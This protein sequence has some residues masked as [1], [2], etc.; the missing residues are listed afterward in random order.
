MSAYTKAGGR[1]TSADH[2]NDPAARICLSQ[3]LGRSGVSLADCP[4][5]SVL[6]GPHASGRTT[7]LRALH[8]QHSDGLWLTGAGVSMVAVFAPLGIAGVTTDAIRSALARRPGIA[9]FIDD[10]D[11]L[12]IECAVLL[13]TLVVHDHITVHLT[14]A[15]PSCEDAPGPIATLWKDSYLPRADM[16][17]LEPAHVLTYLTARFGAPPAASALRAITRQIGDSPRGLV[18]IVDATIE[19]GY[20]RI[21]TGHALLS[22]RPLP[23]PTRAPRHAISE[24]PPEV[25]TVAALL[26]VAASATERY[27]DGWVPTTAL[28]SICGIEALI[29]A[30]RE[31]VVEATNHHVRLR[32]PYIGAL[33]AQELGPI[34]SGELTMAL[35][36]ALASA[37]LVAAQRRLACL[38][39]CLLYLDAAQVPP[40]E[41]QAEA[42]AAASALG[43]P[44]AV[45]RLSGATD[46]DDRIADDSTIA[47]AWL[48]LCRTDQAR[49]M[50]ERHGFSG[51][52]TSDWTEL[53][54]LLGL[55]NTSGS[56]DALNP[57]SPWTLLIEALHLGMQGRETGALFTRIRTI[58]TDDG[59]LVCYADAIEISLHAL[60][61]NVEGAR[62]QAGQSLARHRPGTLAFGILSIAGAFADYCSGRIDS[63]VSQ[64]LDAVDGGLPAPWHAVANDIL[65]KVNWHIDVDDRRHRDQT[66]APPPPLIDGLL[67]ALTAIDS[68][69]WAARSGTPDSATPGL[70][71]AATEAL[72]RA[73]AVVS[74]QLAETALRW[75]RPASADGLGELLA[76]LRQPIDSAAAA[77]IDPVVADRIR[78]LTHHLTA[79]QAAD[80]TGLMEIA[81][82]YREAG[83]RIAAV[84]VLAQASWAFR[85]AG[86]HF[87]ANLCAARAR[88][89]LGE[90]RSYDSPAM[91]LISSDTAGLST[92]EHE[93]GMLV[94]EGHSNREIAHALQLSLRTVEGHVLRACSK[95]G[96]RNRRDLAQLFTLSEEP[97]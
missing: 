3:A 52:D 72:D 27:T 29:E 75:D 38:I 65:H 30:E 97:N 86:N 71:A 39:V 12:D 19:S 87:H 49:R 68:A 14:C 7:A 42:T 11:L 28:L 10:G 22:G 79:W 8:E 44:E 2:V 62:E 66:L 77:S 6:I 59:M 53:R 93:V 74:I 55:F 37:R 56:R 1:T 24:L 50:L 32:I 83:R 51:T 9:L 36:D 60:R 26:G 70:I 57:R 90:S 33:C 63:A 41:L 88:Y 46:R 85:K 95:T 58:A 13:L 91:L 34:R 54:D 21:S 64:L 94:G 73:E 84:D 81:E 45:L 31:K 76:R 89:L 17:P 96:A 5:G 35:C 47:W 40:P 18:E 23:N 43:D 80:G 78:L 25:R 67:N 48:H 20:W 61:G 82:R 4:N 69:W 15:S 16:R 92:R